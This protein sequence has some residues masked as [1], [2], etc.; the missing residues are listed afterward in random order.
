MYYE[1]YADSLFLLYFVLDVY[2]LLL[3]NKL[4]YGNVKVTRLLT[5][6]ALGAVMALLPLFVS[7]PCLKGGVW[8]A[9]S[10]LL[11]GSYTFRI[12]SRKQFFGIMKMLLV[13]MIILGGFITL[14]MSVLPVGRRFWGIA[15]VLIA[16]ALCCK[17][18]SKN[19]DSK[20]EL[21]HFCKVQLVKENQI[22]EVKALLDT[23]NT[24]IEPIS[25]KPVA[26][27]GE[28]LL[29][30]Y[31]GEEIPQVYRVIPFCSVGKR[32]GVLKGYQL[33][34]MRIETD[35]GKKVCK[36]VFVAVSKELLTEGKEYEIILNPKLLL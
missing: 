13:V 30:K 16:G 4:V 11:M 35:G 27:V 9:F 5:G 15:G 12:H 6:A 10:I 34:E 23:G 3:V 36:D 21:G 32:K 29:V 18:L 17:W 14:F 26:V 8:Y 1:V 33:E 7:I 2:V 19:V 20:R 24:L 31:Y 25:G 28:E 22:L